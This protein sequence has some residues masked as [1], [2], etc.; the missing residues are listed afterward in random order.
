MLRKEECAAG[1]EQIA[2]L[3]R[4]VLMKLPRC[5]KVTGIY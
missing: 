4:G 1:M 2:I 5:K 3:I